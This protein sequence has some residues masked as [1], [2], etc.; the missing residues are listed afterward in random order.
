MINMKINDLTGLTFDKLTVLELSMK[1]KSPHW[2]C[3]C[4]CGNIID[5]KTTDLKSGKVH[6]CRECRYK[7]SSKTQ[8]I[9][10]V[11]RKVGYLTIESVEYVDHRPIALCECKCGKQVTIG[12]D[13]LYRKSKNF[14]SCGCYIRSKYEV[15]AREKYGSKIE[16]N[17]YVLLGA[18]DKS[19]NRKR[20]Y[21]FKCKTCNQVFDQT[22]DYILKSKGSCPFCSSRSMDLSGKYFGRLVVLHQ[23]INPYNKQKNRYWLCKCEC[24]N[25]IVVS[26]TN[27][28][29]GKTHQCPQCSIAQNRKDIV[30]F[31]FGKLIVTDVE[32]TNENGEYKTICHCICDCGNK[33]NVLRS[34][35]VSGRTISCGC[36]IHDKKFINRSGETING[37]EFISVNKRGNDGGYL[38]NCR[39][40]YCGH[41]FV[42]YPQ[43]IKSHTVNSCGCQN[44][45]N[46]EILISQ[47]LDELKVSYKTE[48]SFPDCVYIQ[49]L[50]FD[51]CILFDGN[52]ILLIEFDG[53][54]HYQS[55][56]YFGGQEGFRIRQI[57]DEIKNQYCD[58]HDIPLLRIPYYMKYEDIVQSLKIKINTL[59]KSLLNSAA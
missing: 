22:I 31:R 58:M 51:F 19:R 4:D 5:V 17:G 3:I 15:L 43:H 25:Q 24:G 16:S 26:T 33:T 55:I 47:I 23:T 10:Y 20:I 52:P 34:S 32:Y 42:A 1:G 59:Y 56:E 48:Y 54:Q 11:G 49:P 38:W 9:N 35:L 46:G 36:A 44:R 18:T 27:L 28:L 30:G 53:I 45:S 57:C 21:S 40:P 29:S 8:R 37:I 41:I 50:K 6:Q 2:K 13:A 14:K 7:Q 39:C 12:I